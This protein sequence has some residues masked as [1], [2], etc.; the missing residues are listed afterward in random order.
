MIDLKAARANPDEY[1]KALARKGKDAEFDRLLDADERWR[2]LV[3][4]VDDLRARQKLNGKPTAEQIE[5]LKGVKEELRV[6]EEALTAAEAERDELLRAVPNPPHESAPD[7]DAEEDAEEIKRW[8]EPPE[9]AEPKEHTEIGRFDMERA[10]RLS[11][12]RFGYLIGDTALVALA[13]YRFAI[14]HALRAGCTPMI[15]PILV[16][17]EAMYG[18]GF[19]PT[20]ASNIYGVEKDGLYLT[21]TSEVAL[22]GLHMGEILEELPVRYSAFSTN[23]RRESGAAGRDTRG[24]FRVHQFNKVELFAFVRPEDSWDEHERMLAVEEQIVQELGLPYRV[25][26][27]AAGDLGDPAAKK[28][29]IE[30]WFPSQDRYREITSCSNT[31]DFQA[32]RL[33]IRYRKENSGLEYVHTLNGTAVTDRAVLA[34]LENFQG[35][36]PEALHAFGAPERIEH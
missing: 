25:V 2:Q 18:T 5:E 27:V 13:L 1:R 11:G 17:E 3:P 14:E 8:G 29:D 6:Q 30:A 24:M 31:T 12:S 7:G 16:R 26:N 35:D 19:F 15:P 21:G 34:I 4:T 10:A 20:E 32:R 36:V 22:A 33:G 28:Y 9:L 23:F